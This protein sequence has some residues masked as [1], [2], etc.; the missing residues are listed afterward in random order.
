MG[1]ASVLVKG[2]HRAGEQMQDLLLCEGEVF[3]YS[4]CRV[5]TP[6]L[7]GTGCTLAS[8]IAANLLLGEALPQAVARA[9]RY[10]T[11][12]LQAGAVRRLGLGCGPMEHRV[13]LD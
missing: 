11:R 5:D 2:G 6:N 1:V 3:E 8:A 13:S 9:K 12:A 10:L 7:H 4:E